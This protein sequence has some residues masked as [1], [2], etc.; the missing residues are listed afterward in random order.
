MYECHYEH[1]P[2]CKYSAENCGRVATHIR[3]VHV[4]FCVG[5]QYCPRNPGQVKHG[6][7]HFKTHHPEIVAVHEYANSTSAHDTVLEHR[8]SPTRTPLTSRPFSPRINIMAQNNTRWTAPTFSF[9]TADQ[10]A[11]W[12]EFYMRAIDYLETMDIDPEKED[13]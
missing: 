5:C 9:D 3:H 11:T 1:G 13:Q 12:K 6:G 7:D 2:E 10:P 8:F 4:G